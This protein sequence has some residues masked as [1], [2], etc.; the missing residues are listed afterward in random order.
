MAQAHLFQIF[1]NEAT[2]DQLDPGFTPLDNSANTRP[3]WFEYLP[4]RQCLLTQE[5]AEDDYLGIFSPK[6]FEKTG[7][8]SQAVR[9]VLAKTD[10]PVVSFSPWFGH[11][12]LHRNVFLQA[13]KN[14]PGANHVF[15][16]VLPELGLSLDIRRCVMST[17][18]AIY[19]NYFVAKPSV[20]RQWY[21]LADRLFELAEDKTTELGRQ[22]RQVTVY[23]GPQGSPMK[24]FVLER[25]ISAWLSSQEQN[26]LF[27][28]DVQTCLLGYGLKHDELTLEV[29]STLDDLKKNYLQTG[30]MDCLRS[31]EELRQEL[32]AVEY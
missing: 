3:D 4:I 26:A 5:L 23:K 17:E 18:Q 24:I 14:H 30:D 19:C 6:F 11:L 32:V 21:L 29:L 20:W 27:A 22:L 7:M 28:T 1:Y 25:L 15:D 12:A 8:R 31:F 16:A 10:A 13:E 9:D 2:R